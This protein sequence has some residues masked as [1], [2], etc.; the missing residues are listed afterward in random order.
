MEL[1][2][3]IISFKLPTGPS[4]FKVDLKESL[5]PILLSVPSRSTMEIVRKHVPLVLDPQLSNAP[6]AE[7][8]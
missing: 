3:L 2:S 8:Y 1:I 4:S 6:A 7:D 5:I